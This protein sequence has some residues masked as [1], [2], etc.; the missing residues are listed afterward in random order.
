M[1]DASFAEELA[2]RDGDGRGPGF[3]AFAPRIR[4]ERIVREG[5]V[6][7]ETTRGAVEAGRVALA[8][9]GYTGPATPWLRRRVIPVRA[10]IAA[11]EPL[12]PALMDRLFPTARSFSD[13]AANLTWIRA[14]TDRTRI[15]FG[16]RT[17]MAERGLR[18][19]AVR[20]RAAA[21]RLVPELA[22][23]RI[24]HCWECRMGFTFDQVPHLGQQDDLYYAVGFCGA[25]LAGGTWLGDRLGHMLLGSD[26][27]DNPLAG[28]P[29]P[30]RPYYRGRPWFMP[31]LVARIG[32][33]DRLSRQRH[34]RGS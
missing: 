17:D 1:L 24:D 32:L 9:N 34:S 30:A 23:L 10:S 18:R 29:F 22:N 21:A 33:A 2:Q 8:T 15:L 27:A 12:D 16:G 20:M 26:E 28:V 6:R 4:V 14:S 11:T 19:K 25:G 5:T 7:V 31:Y 13:T 3:G